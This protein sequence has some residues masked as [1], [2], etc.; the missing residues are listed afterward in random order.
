MNILY[1]EPYK[2][3]ENRKFG[4]VTIR[5]K[6]EAFEDVEFKGG[7]LT[8]FFYFCSFNKLIIENEDLI[9]SFLSIK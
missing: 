2:P 1:A 4:D 6:K 9:K 7:T 3:T 8:V 5:I